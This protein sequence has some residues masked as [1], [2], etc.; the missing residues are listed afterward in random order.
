[1]KNRAFIK[2]S[3]YWWIGWLIDLPGVNSQEKTKK[4]LLK[5][6]TIGAQDMLT[7]EVPFEPGS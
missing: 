1:M 5:S 3:G 6:L 4:E 2:K 7:A